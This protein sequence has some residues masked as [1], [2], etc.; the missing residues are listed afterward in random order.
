MIDE[1]QQE[2]VIKAWEDGMRAIEKSLGDNLTT[3]NF[4]FITL[5]MVVPLIT[6]FDKA[7]P[8]E[9]ARNRDAF[10]HAVKVS[11]NTRIDAVKGKEI[12]RASVVF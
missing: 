4:Y 7:T 6:Q 2:M 1:K 11:I 8:K 10:L 9:M 12:K 3:E 5:N